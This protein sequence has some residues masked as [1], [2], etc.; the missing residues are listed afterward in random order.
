MITYISLLRGINVSG[1]NSI[2]MDALRKLF[3]ESS[4]YN[5]T[6]YIQSGNII[7]NSNETNLKKLEQLIFNKI[8]NKFGFNVP[9]I[10][11]TIDELEQSLNKNPF[12]NNSDEKFVHFT[13]LKDLPTI[14]YEKEINNKKALNEEIKIINKTIY[15]Y[16]PD[17]YGKTKLT[18][19]YL[20]KI[21]KV[22]STT[23]NLKTTRQL[24]T[25][26]KEINN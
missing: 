11:L 23:R 16:C 10:I 2:K 18:N 17:G 26:A 3:E 7:F 12:S 9:V 5:V 14:S 24:F 19:N 8:L 22:S 21:L 6:T 1:K 13:F 15:L 4:F 20:E 25:I